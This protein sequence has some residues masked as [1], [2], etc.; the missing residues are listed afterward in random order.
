MPKLL[1]NQPLSFFYNSFVLLMP[2]E[3]FFF[4]QYLLGTYKNWAVLNDFYVRVQLRQ[5]YFFLFRLVSRGNKIVVFF[6]KDN[7]SVFRELFPKGSTHY[8]T[9]NVQKGV[10]FLEKFAQSKNI[11]GVVFIG[12]F[13]NYSLKSLNKFSIPI[14]CISP[15]YKIASEYSL[16]T[17]L[18]SIHPLLLLKKI[19][20]QIFLVPSLKK[21]NNE[22]K[23][24]I[25]KFKGFKRVG[26]KRF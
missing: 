10:Q 18:N 5:I 26:Q 13:L 11:G 7:F 21:K 20:H 19:L 24:T 8:A 12:S 22:K 15:N 1:K 6:E 2:R 3:S 16:Y 4:K 9:D 17:Q 25:Q 23:K 14:L